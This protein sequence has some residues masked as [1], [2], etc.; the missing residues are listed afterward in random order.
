MFIGTIDFYHF[1]PL[2]LTLN[3]AGVHKISWK[4]NLLAS[5]SRTLQL[6]RMKFDLVLKQF[7]LN[8][9]IPLLSDSWFKKGNNHCFND[10]WKISKVG[11]HLDTCE[12]IWYNCGIMIDS[13]QLYI[14]TLVLLSMTLIQG[15]RSGRKQKLLWQLS[16]KPFNQF[17]I[18]LRFVSLMNC[19]LILSHPFSIQGRETC[20]SN[21]HL[22]KNYF[23]VG[24]HS[25]IYR[26]VSFNRMW[27]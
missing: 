12:L 1:I 19:I 15:H 10:C 22:K 27:W 3:L 26:P 18:L 4:Q 5:F 21:F 6:I 16:H 24:L 7:K 11:M 2:L 14:V 25:D 9:L 20:L 17:G 23:N 13:I 8:I